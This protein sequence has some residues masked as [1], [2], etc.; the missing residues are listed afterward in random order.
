MNNRNSWGHLKSALV[1]A[2]ELQKS[3]PYSPILR[4]RLLY[5]FLLMFLLSGLAQA[6]FD[7][8]LR[9]FG[10]AV[11]QIQ[12]YDNQ[13]KSGCHDGYYLG[14]NNYCIPNGSIQCDQDPRKSCPGDKKCAEVNGV[15]GCYA[16]SELYN[17][18]NLNSKSN[19]GQG[20]Y[21]QRGNDI[22]LK[23]SQ[24]EAQRKKSI[25]DNEDRILQE[26]K[27]LEAEEQRHALSQ[28]Q[29][30]PDASKYKSDRKT[31][32]KLSFEYED[33]IPGTGE[34]DWSGECVDGFAEGYGVARFYVDNTLYWVW[35][36]KPESGGK[37]QKGV[38]KL[39][40]DFGELRFKLNSCKRDSMQVEVEIP[41]NLNLQFSDVFWKIVDLGSKYADLKTVPYLDERD[42]RNGFC[43][44]YGYGGTEKK[45]RDKE[46]IVYQGGEQVGWARSD[47]W[48]KQSR[49]SYKFGSEIWKQWNIQKLILAENYRKKVFN[50]ARKKRIE[51]QRIRAIE[52]AKQKLL[53][54]LE[55][56]RER[57]KERPADSFCIFSC[58]PI[59]QNGRLVLE[60]RLK[61]I[62][63]TQVIIV[64]FRK[65][66]GVRS[67]SNGIENYELHYKVNVE[68]PHGYVKSAGGLLGR[69]AVENTMRELKTLM[70][71][72]EGTTRG[73]KWSDPASFVGTGKLVFRKTEQGWQGSDGVVYEEDKKGREIA[74][75]AGIFILL[76]GIGG[77]VWRLKDV[78]ST[79]LEEYSGK[80]K[81]MI[82]DIADNLNKQK[83]ED[84]SQGDISG[85]F[86]AVSTS[87][88][89]SSGKAMKAANGFA[90]KLK[91]NNQI[92]RMLGNTIVFVIL[93]VLFMVPTYVLSWLGSNSS[94][95]NA[96]SS[97]V[98]GSL[99]PQFWM[100]L[101]ALS[102][103][104]VIAWFRG[105]LIEKKWL[106][107]FPIMAAAFDM[108]PGLSLVPLVPTV[109]HLCAIIVGV[110]NPPTIV[111]PEIGAEAKNGDDVEAGTDNA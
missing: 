18:R 15:L 86:E 52:R 71:D 30:T 48:R 62:I 61:K 73:E 40:V 49:N 7:D 67:E 20:Q 50:E 76:F 84:G 63:K 17:S 45:S 79:R 41:Q 28:E 24:R 34:F 19:V 91:N 82:N 33:D 111:S 44:R 75:Y 10:K 72:Y 68:L 47:R 6:G 54:A 85:I 23:Q 90:G 9:A 80:A 42:R 12:N 4:Y 46:I 32:C 25:Q 97:S 89:Q 16:G 104:I 101:A 3:S 105:V 93:Y 69:I 83:A 98:V 74:T 59:E 13:K 103:L 22:W 53:A 100:H 27:E 37:I 21:D 109:M 66:N 81:A 88:A 94:A 92:I 2:Q 108:L 107:I 56:A 57:D 77:I 110:K 51:E 8:A 38:F 96:M 43:P 55:D 64:K 70:D 1:D 102:I 60:N 36:V 99:S 5:A 29:K 106:V 58:D 11:D 78:I 14:K 87:L 31:G 95:F 39:D 26:L 35:D 65:T